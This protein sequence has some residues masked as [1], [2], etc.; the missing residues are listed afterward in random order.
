[1]LLADQ[2]ISTQYW[3]VLHQSSNEISHNSEIWV[4]IY[5]FNIG[6]TVYI[7]SNQEAAVL[8]VFLETRYCSPFV[9]WLHSEMWLLPQASSACK[10]QTKA[11]SA[12]I[13]HP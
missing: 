12:L 8:S 6:N 2:L 10:L 1:M 9:Y 13:N 11:G 7:F 4:K 3:A 5:L